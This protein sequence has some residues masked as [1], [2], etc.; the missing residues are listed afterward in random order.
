M[1]AVQDAVQVFRVAPTPPRIPVLVLR[2]RVPQHVRQLFND[3]DEDALWMVVGAPREGV[4]STLEMTEEQLAA[5]YPDDPN[6]LPPELGGGI[7][8]I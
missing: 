6:A 5:M 3:S 8:T 7:V 1:Y 2:R 4:S